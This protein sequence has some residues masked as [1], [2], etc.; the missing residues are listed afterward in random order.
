MYRIAFNKYLILAI[1]SA[2]LIQPAHA[3][4]AA[5]NLGTCS[6]YDALSSELSCSNETG[7]LMQFGARYCHQFDENFSRFSLNGQRVLTEIR[8]CLQEELEKTPELTCGNVKAV[9]AESHVYCY[10]QARFCQMSFLD[11]FT[12][13]QIVAPAILD[14]DLRAAVKRIERECLAEIAN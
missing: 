11:Q 2:F 6:Y 12:L 7:Y 13:M 8:T 4:Q 14:P 5:E 1:F 3:Y 9:A 10:R